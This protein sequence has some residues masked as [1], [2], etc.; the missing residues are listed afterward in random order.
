MEFKDKLQLIRTQMRLSQE[1]L[2]LKLNVSRQSVTKWENGQSF[3]DI[4]NLYS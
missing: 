3:P 1:D 4:D 2:A